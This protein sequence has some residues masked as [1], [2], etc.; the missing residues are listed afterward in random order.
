MDLSSHPPVNWKLLF[1]QRGFRY[2]FAGIFVSLFGSGMNFAGVTWYVLAVTHSTVSVGFTVILYTAPGL[3]VPFLGGVLID[4]V[5]RRYLCILLDLCRGVLV[6]SV[7]ALVHFGHA[8]VWQINLMVFLSGAGAAIYWAS[9]NALVQELIPADQFVGANSFVLIAVQGGLMLAGAFVGFVYEHAGLA[10]ILGIDGLTYLVS[11]FCLWR[12]RQGSRLAYHQQ[13][14][15]DQVGD[16]FADV[17]ETASIPPVVE[18]TLFP[19]LAASVLRDLREGINYLAEQPGVLALGITYATMMAGIISG[20]VLAV[21][22][23]KDI[24]QAGAVGFG[25][26]EAGWAVGAVLGGL[27]AGYIARRHPLNVLVLAMALLA[28]GHALVPFVT[29]LFA[30]V[31]L[32]GLFGACRAVGG[33]LTQSSVMSVVPR[34]LMGRTQSA[35]SIMSTV[36]QVVM[37]FTLGWVGQHVGL[38]AAFGVLALVYAGAILAAFRARSLSKHALPVRG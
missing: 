12:L 25:Y 10:G 18:T 2:F 1:A 21:A 38:I 5:D 9:V 23:A 35:F 16:A 31:A 37:S 17:L 29:V 28:I 11:A 8:P 4:R 36:L 20:N 14:V 33:I 7:A 6:L 3:I 13:P 34:R 26:I 15:I 30:A 22:L 32:Q 27:A 24:L 19:N